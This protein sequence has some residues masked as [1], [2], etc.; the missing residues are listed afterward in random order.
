MEFTENG[1]NDLISVIVP[2]YGVEQFLD[3]CVESI[4]G[5]THKNLEIILVDDGSP[6]NCPAM[7]DAWA[8]RDSRI[9]VIHKVNGGLSDARNAG[10]SVATGDFLAFV[11]SDDWI[12]SN[13]Y[14][15]M[16]KALKEADADFCA[17][18]IIDSYSDKEILHSSRPHTGASE[19]FLAM[20]YHDTI[21]SVAAWNKLYCKKMWEGFEFPKGKICE[22]AFTTYLLVDRAN[23][24]TQIEAPCYHYRIREN[25]IMTSAFRPARMDEEEAWRCNYEY[26]KQHH[27]DIASAAYDFYLQK[28]HVLIKTIRPDQILQYNSCYMRLFTILSKNAGYV[29]F[30]SALPIKY[31]IRYIIDLIE[32]AKHKGARI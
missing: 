25:S 3:Q 26:M 6:D 20:I 17:C 21:F 9:Q 11:D 12:E 2:V 19:E 18:G 31:R 32:L 10:L 24:I 13:M 5:Q 14:E 16:L 7:C 30:R 8:A 4:V 29:M 23:R 1:M 28:V 27:P 22:D 15:V